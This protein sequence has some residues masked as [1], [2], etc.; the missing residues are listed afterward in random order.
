MMAEGVVV[1]ASAGSTPQPL[2]GGSL[3]WAGATP[4]RGARLSWGQVACLGVLCEGGLCVGDGVS[5]FFANLQL[6]SGG[7]CGPLA[8]RAAGGGPLAWRAA[9][10]RSTGSVFRGPAVHPSL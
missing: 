7:A 9:G 5:L 6:G 1:A 4:Q 3:F 10:R 8:R 2:F